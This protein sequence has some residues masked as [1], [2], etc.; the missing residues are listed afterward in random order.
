M[1]NAQ[2]ARPKPITAVDWSF[3]QRANRVDE[4][5]RYDGEPNNA[6]EEFGP[7]LSTVG[8]LRTT[9]MDDSRRMPMNIVLAHRK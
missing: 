6:I 3:F 7:D 1:I 9:T 2:M 4:A 5:Q 8:I